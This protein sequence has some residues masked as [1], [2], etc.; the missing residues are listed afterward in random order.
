M[1][2]DRAWSVKFQQLIDA[3]GNG[4]DT[5]SAT[6]PSK[7]VFIKTA[8]NM[9]ADWGIRYSANLASACTS[10][11]LDS[12]DVKDPPTVGRTESTLSTVA[13]S[14]ASATI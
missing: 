13:G 5:K 14:V 3:L 2:V 9:Q 6:P 12:E 1:V 10:V 11:L 8:G 4:S 7:R